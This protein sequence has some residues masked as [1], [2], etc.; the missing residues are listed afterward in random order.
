MRIFL[1]CAIGV[2]GL[3]IV[4]FTVQRHP[5]IP[6]PSHLKT[7]LYVEI[8]EH[9]DVTRNTLPGKRCK[10]GEPEHMELTPSHLDMAKYPNMTPYLQ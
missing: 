2:D 9:Q 3:A 7:I 8:K 5:L 4:N 10:L 1:C 6:T